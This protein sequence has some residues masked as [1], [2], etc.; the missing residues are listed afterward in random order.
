[1]RLRF[2]AT[3]IGLS[4]LAGLV[5]AADAFT[6]KGFDATA[7]GGAVYEPRYC[8]PSGHLPMNACLMANMVMGE[9]FLLRAIEAKYGLTEFPRQ[10]QTLQA[11]VQRHCAVARE[12]AVKR[13]KSGEL[14]DFTFWSCLRSEYH[15][16]ALE[17]LH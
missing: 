10:R 17:L 11:K 13:Y 15:K 8:D 9:D 7:Y 4:G 12:A 3:L 16:S 2:L 14:I 6:S 5:S 1:M